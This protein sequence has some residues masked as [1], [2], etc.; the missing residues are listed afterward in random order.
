MNEGSLVTETTGDGY[1]II[2]LESEA[3]E[4][5]ITPTPY[6]PASLSFVSLVSEGDGEPV[7][8]SVHPSS[9]TE[10]GSEGHHERRRRTKPGGRASQFLESKGFG[11]LMEVEE[12]EGEEE[13]KP[14]L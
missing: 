3:S 13:N 4:P 7:S 6:D 14:L 9:E 10:W 2:N 12:E 8:G 5:Q 11:W 1:Q